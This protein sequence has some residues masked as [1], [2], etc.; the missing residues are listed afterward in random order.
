MARSYYKTFEELGILSK[1]EN[2]NIYNLPTD[3][4][5]NV[6]IDHR[7]GDLIAIL[8][9]GCKIE[10]KTLNGNVVFMG[11]DIVAYEENPFE[12][13]QKGKI[14]ENINVYHYTVQKLPKPFDGKEYLLKGPYYHDALLAHWPSNQEGLEYYSNVGTPE[15][16]PSSINYEPTEFE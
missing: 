1:L 15:A 4:W 8:A 3:A 2:W 6:P 9:S 13:S 14:E 10:P 16:P 11:V 7:K 5:K 12:K